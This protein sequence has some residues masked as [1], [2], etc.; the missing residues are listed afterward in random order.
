MFKKYYIVNFN[1]SMYVYDLHKMVILQRSY[2]DSTNLLHIKE[3][4]ELLKC[5]RNISMVENRTKSSIV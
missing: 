2:N 5:R 3:E 1:I 4:K